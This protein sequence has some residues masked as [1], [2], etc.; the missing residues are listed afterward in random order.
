MCDITVKKVQGQIGSMLKFGP[1]PVLY[2][3]K[4]W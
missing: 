2:E 1:A 3:G 4:G